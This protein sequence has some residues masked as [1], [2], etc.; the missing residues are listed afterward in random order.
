[1]T[2]TEKI[3]MQKECIRKKKERARV[4]SLSPEEKKQRAKDL[5]KKWREEHPN[6]LKKWR[7]KNKQKIKKMKRTTKEEQVASG[8]TMYAISQKSGVNY[9]TVLS[10]FNHESNVTLSTQNKIEKALKELLKK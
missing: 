9:N 10:Y 7:A 6:Y 3:A 2:I 1:M 4:R 5:A 8:I